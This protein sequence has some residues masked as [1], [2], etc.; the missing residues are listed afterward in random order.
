[1]DPNDLARLPVAA[2]RVACRL[3]RELGAAPYPAGDTGLEPRQPL[4]QHV[5][6]EGAPLKERTV[7]STRYR[8]PIAR[9][10]AAR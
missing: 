3:E 6:V 5:I 9:A 8:P 10:R 2:G 4:A 1:M 7:V